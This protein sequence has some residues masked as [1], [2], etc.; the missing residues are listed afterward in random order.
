M[1]K[2]GIFC[3]LSFRIIFPDKCPG[4]PAHFMKR[5]K[6]KACRKCFR[7]ACVLTSVPDPIRF[8]DPADKFFY[9][10]ISGFVF[11]H[12]HR[13]SE[14]NRRVRERNADGR[15]IIDAFFDRFADLRLRGEEIGSWRMGIG[16]DFPR[17]MQIDWV[18]GRYSEEELQTLQPSIDMAV[19]IIKSFVL[20]GIDFTM[21][22]Y[23]KLGKRKREVKA[24]SDGGGGED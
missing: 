11:F 19:D 13:I 8:R 22:Q 17:G 10:G 9:P 6:K 1:Q 3:R 15:L 2:T 20:S 7:Q 4:L 23:N 16:N 12:F 21:N 18:L 14:K 5:R 24:K